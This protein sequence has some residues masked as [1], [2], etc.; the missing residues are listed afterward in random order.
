MGGFAGVVRG[1]LAGLN[2]A[3]GNPDT[4]AALRQRQQQEQQGQMDELRAKILPHQFAI[5]G[6]QTK[7]QSLDPQKDAEQYAAITH[8][9]ARNLA[10][11]RQYIHPDKDSKGNF[12][13][14]GITDKIHLTSLKNRQDKEKAAQ[15]KGAAE[16]ESGAQALAQGTVPYTQDPKFL[17]STALEKQRAGAADALE[18]KRLAGARALE[19]MRLDQKEK[20]GLKVMGSENSPYGVQNQDTGQQYLPSQLGE[21][22]DAPPEAKQ[23]WKTLQD[24][25]A[26]KEADEQKKEDER[27]AR[28]AKTIAAGFDRMGRTQEFQENMAQYRAD[29]TTYRGLDKDARNSEET[30]KALDEQYKQPGNKAVADNEL[31]NFY[32]SVVQKGGRKTAAELALTLKV[33]SL[34]M[35]LETMAK[36]AASGEL[37]DD[38]RKQLLSGM[39]AVADEQRAM[40]DQ[41]KPELPAITGGNKTK[42]LKD[43]RR[44]Q[45]GG[46]PDA[47]KKQ[48]QEGKITT[49]ANGQK[50]T[51]ESGQPKQVK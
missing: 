11:V 10:E 32:T 37:P 15:T 18:D 30:V 49:F 34:G 20:K 41:T 1:A 23:I 24:A 44:D 35:N 22:G 27:D 13:E 33:G 14:R 45:K 47:A 26:A 46:L 3:A 16:D 25:K 43:T 40:A 36:K 17:E 38:L 4:A 9:I 50:W 31:Q 6:L 7:L 51:L 2:E 28:Q 39:K 5:K 42:A 48:L 19:Q 8:D 12:F 21:K 29:L